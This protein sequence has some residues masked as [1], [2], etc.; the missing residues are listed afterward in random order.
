MTPVRGI[1]GAIQVVENEPE[2][3]AAATRELLSTMVERNGIDA[4]ALVAIWFTQ[5]DDLDAAHAAASARELGWRRVPLMSG[6]EVAVPGQMPRIVRALALAEIDGPAT[7]VRHAYLGA[8]R[9]LRE[10]LEEEEPT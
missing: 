9:A 7:A 2:S 5:T 10:D 3:I 4:S 6:V 8:A 1:R